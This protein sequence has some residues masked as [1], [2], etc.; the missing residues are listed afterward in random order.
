[1][2]SSPAILVTLS[3]LG[4]VALGCVYFTLLYHAL[5]LQQA[6]APIGAVLGAHLVR[7]AL[8]LAAFWGLV[9]LGA[10]PLLAGLAGFLL[11]RFGAQR[12]VA[13]P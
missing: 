11:A 12:L 5:R 1:M 13:G 7:V 8:A 6:A 3:L 10:W 4:G 2:N 9:Q